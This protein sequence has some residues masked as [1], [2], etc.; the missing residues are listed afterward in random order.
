MDIM[1]EDKV[2][3]IGTIKL[4]PGVPLLHQY[5]SAD[6]PDGNMVLLDTEGTNDAPTLDNLSTRYVLIV[7][8]QE[9]IDAA[10]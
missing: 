1:D 5:V 10:V 9:E 3:I 4:V 2:L 6:L 7:A 8:P